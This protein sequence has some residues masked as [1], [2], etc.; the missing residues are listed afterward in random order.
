MTRILKTLARTMR[1]NLNDPQ[2]HFHSGT[3]GRAYPCFDSHCTSPH[4]SVED[5]V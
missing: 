2:T 3:G 1:D 4:R 5:A